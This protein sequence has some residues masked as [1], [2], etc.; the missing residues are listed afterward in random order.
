MPSEARF[1]VEVLTDETAVAVITASSVRPE[2]ITEAL[3]AVSANFPG[4]S[5][6]GAVSGLFPIGGN[7]KAGHAF[8]TAGQLNFKTK[9]SREV[10]AKAMEAIKN[11][12]IA[13]HFGIYSDE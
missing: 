1:I 6:E 3:K 11:A 7:P 9:P 8:G 4:S 10:L 2:V 13:Q 12:L 5:V